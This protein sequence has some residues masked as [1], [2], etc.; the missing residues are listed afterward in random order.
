MEL[1]MND[2]KNKLS[3]MLKIIEQLDNQTVLAL[4]GVA[5]ILA[6]II[7]GLTDVLILVFGM[8]LGVALAKKLL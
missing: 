6:L 7:G 5:V 2:L 4:S 3:P 8:W 1:G